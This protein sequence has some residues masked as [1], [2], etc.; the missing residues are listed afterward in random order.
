MNLWKKLTA[1]TL[2]VAA[3]AALCALPA[4]A[5]TMSRMHSMHPAA[6]LHRRAV[7]N[8]HRATRAARN[9]HPKR[10]ERYAAKAQHQYNRSYRMR[11][12]HNRRMY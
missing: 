1:S 12:R 6:T 11:M 5:Q 2:A 9:G 3:A 8:A 7:M 10:S 4:S